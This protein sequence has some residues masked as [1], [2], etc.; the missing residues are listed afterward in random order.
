MKKIP[1]KDVLF[2][3]KGIIL[4]ILTNDDI[5][6]L[7]VITSISESFTI[8]SFVVVFFTHAEKRQIKKNIPILC[9]DKDIREQQ[10]HF[11]KKVLFILF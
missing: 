8:L 1:N 10:F 3:S 7:E 5:G 6:N 2:V 4:F 11:I 9:L